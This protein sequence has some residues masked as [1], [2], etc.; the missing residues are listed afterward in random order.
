MRHSSWNLTIAGVV[1][2]LATLA[3]PARAQLPLNTNVPNLSGFGIPLLVVIAEVA[4]GNTANFEL[5]ADGQFDFTDVAT[6]PEVGPIFNSRSCG[7]CHFQPALGG[8]GG[9]IN[10]VRTLDLKKLP[11]VSETID[12]ARV[13]VLLQAPELGHEVVKDTLNVLLKY[14]ADIEATMPQVST[15]IA[16]VSRHNVF[17]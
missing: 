2:G 6:L 4:N 7:G 16:K 8:S 13:L 17:G 5:F 11:S 12:W 10:E 14:E 3:A 15:F 1:V 9:F